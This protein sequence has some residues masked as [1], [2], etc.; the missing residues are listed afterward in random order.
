MHFAEWAAMF[1][2]LGARP[3]LTLRSNGG[4]KKKR[5]GSSR[6]QVVAM[7]VPLQRSPSGGLEEF[8]AYGIDEKDWKIP[9]P[10]LNGHN[11]IDVDAVLVSDLSRPS[12]K[13]NRAEWKVESDGASASA[14]QPENPQTTEVSAANSQEAVPLLHRWKTHEV[15]SARSVHVALV[16]SMVMVLL[17][18]VAMYLFRAAGGTWGRKYV[19]YSKSEAAVR[20]ELTPLRAEATGGKDAEAVQFLNKKIQ[21]RLDRFEERLMRAANNLKESATS[22]MSQTE[23][24]S[25]VSAVGYTRQS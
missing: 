8:T 10:K 22:E 17:V 7:E 19:V 9:S 11:G 4:E 25:S 24:V 3:C 16:I 2:L 18:A 14:L 6:S 15:L 23:T 1:L 13:D 5:I 12:F 21:A 20:E